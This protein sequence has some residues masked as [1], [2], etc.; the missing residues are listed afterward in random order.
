MASPKGV[1]MNAVNTSG[2][3]DLVQTFTVV[4]SIVFDYSYR[5]R[6]VNVAQRLAPRERSVFNGRNCIMV[7]P[8]PDNYVGRQCP[9]KPITQKE[10]DEYVQG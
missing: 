10:Y 5:L 6:K 9:L 4:E 2:E 1:I 7:V 3:P 8:F